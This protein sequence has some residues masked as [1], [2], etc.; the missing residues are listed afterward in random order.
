MSITSYFKE[1]KIKRLKKKLRDLYLDY[2]DYLNA[3]DCG[4][5]LAQYVCSNTAKIEKEFNKTYS[6]L[7]ALDPKCPDF[8]LR[9]E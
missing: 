2:Y 4:A 5:M 8:K 3:S 9:K 7:K 1:R 6:K